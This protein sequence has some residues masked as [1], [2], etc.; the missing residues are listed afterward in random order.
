MNTHAHM[1]THAHMRKCT[2]MR[3]CT[4]LQFCAEL[5]DTSQW[6]GT[7]RHWVSEVTISQHGKLTDFTVVS[8]IVR[9][10]TYK[11]AVS[12][13]ETSSLLPLADV[14]VDLANIAT[15]NPLFCG[16]QLPEAMLDLPVIL[17]AKFSIGST[18]RN[19]FWEAGQVKTDRCRWNEY[20]L[21]ANGPFVLAYTK[22]IEHVAHT[23][24]EKAIHLLPAKCVA[25]A[26]EVKM[27]MLFFLFLPCSISSF[28]SFISFI[29]FL[30]F[31]CV[32]GIFSAMAKLC[33]CCHAEREECQSVSQCM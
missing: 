9:S 7:E 23:Q 25:S 12:A 13:A 6:C 14:A 5:L 31:L 21:G 24:P 15:S 29:S 2:H 16:T 30:I 22:L 26:N 28:I 19:I 10:P 11:D 32:D 27:N 4:Y 20:L 18:R 1:H 17:N 3:T 33:M 8:A